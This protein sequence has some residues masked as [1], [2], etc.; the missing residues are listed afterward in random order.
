MGDFF[1]NGD[2]NFKADSG[3]SRRYQL[4]GEA[5]DLLRQF[6]SPELRRVFTQSEVKW[7]AG[8]AG[9]TFIMFKDGLTDEQVKTTDFKSYLEEAYSIFK[10]VLPQHSMPKKR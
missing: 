7:A 9:D 4:R 8:G 2:I 1:K 5:S 3:F 10:T 6:F